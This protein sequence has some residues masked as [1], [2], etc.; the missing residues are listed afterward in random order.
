M[1]DDTLTALVARGLINAIITAFN[2]YAHELLKLKKERTLPYM[3]RQQVLKE[4][5]ISDGT[6]DTWE[7]KGL[8][9]YKPK[10]KTSLVYYRI[11]DICQF[12]VLD[13]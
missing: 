6:L 12:M 11:E 5:D 13:Q 4:M 3:P 9:R 2:H 7:K 1:N 10:Y 8:K